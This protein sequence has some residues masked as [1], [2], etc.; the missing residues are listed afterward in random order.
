LAL[1]EDLLL[2][3]LPEAKLLR[4]LTPPSYWKELLTLETMFAKPELWP[5]LGWLPLSFTFMDWRN[6]VYWLAKVLVF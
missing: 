1:F 3:V 6:L 4:M 2:K 5:K